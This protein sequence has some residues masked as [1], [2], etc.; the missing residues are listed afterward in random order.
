[1]LERWRTGRWRLGLRDLLS[2]E[3]GLLPRLDLARGHDLPQR[4]RRI[5]HRT[6]I[7]RIKTVAVHRVHITV[8]SNASG[9]ELQIGVQQF[10]ELPAAAV[11]AGAEKTSGAPVACQ[12]DALHAAVVGDS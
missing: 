3:R 4:T 5:A 7:R 1:M 12:V 10:L 8:L 9:G 11:P 2:R 6:A